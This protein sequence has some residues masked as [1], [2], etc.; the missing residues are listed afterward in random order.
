MKVLSRD[1]LNQLI[2]Y[3]QAA[4]LQVRQEIQQPLQS[5]E[6]ETLILGSSSKSLGGLMLYSCEGAWWYISKL[7]KSL[8]CNILSH[9]D[10][11]C[12]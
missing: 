3:E 1:V 5:L 6:K 12:L 7:L 4:S 9:E 2:F 10:Q 8:G 11:T